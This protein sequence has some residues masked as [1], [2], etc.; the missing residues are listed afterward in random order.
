MIKRILSLLVVF[1]CASNLSFAGD[2]KYYTCSDPYDMNSKFRSVMGTITGYN[3]TSKKI[4][5]S[6]IKRD[7]GKSLESK[8]LKVKLDSY[9]T[10]D[11]KNG[12]FKSLSITGDNVDSDGIYLSSLK[13]QTLCDFNYIQESSDGEVVFKEDFPMSFEMTMSAD[14]LNKTLQSA[15]YQRVIDNINKYSL[16]GIKISST[17]VDIVGDH[18]YYIIYVSLPF[19]RNEKKIIIGADI[20]AENGQID[21]SKA[22]LTASSMRL[23]MSKIDFLL[24]YLNPLEFSVNI[25]NNRDAKVYVSDLKIE[26]NIVKTSGIIVIPKG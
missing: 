15:R 8:N 23:D 25:L 11:L 14:D 9:S 22:Y 7:I 19:V 13:M 16:G 5:Q 18:F 2:C 24:D 12:I 4:A 26:D 1:M 6:I 3:F 21:Y 10:K 17:K 20:S